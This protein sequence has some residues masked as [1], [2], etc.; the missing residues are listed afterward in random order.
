MILIQ[1][2]YNLFFYKL[3]ELNT[4]LDKKIG[5]KSPTLEWL[6][7]NASILLTIII[8]LYLI[9]IEFIIEIMTGKM[10]VPPTESFWW[11]FHLP[12]FIGLTGIVYCIVEKSCKWIKQKEEFESYSKEKKKKI[13]ILV[14]SIGLG[15]I[16]AF[17]ITLNIWGEFYEA[18][19]IDDYCPITY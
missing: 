4:L 7:F 11:G 3:V 17:I 18:G 10:L 6:T 5:I 16:L 12:F 2:H 9:S 1:R 15:S 14:A 19:L 8:M 13:N